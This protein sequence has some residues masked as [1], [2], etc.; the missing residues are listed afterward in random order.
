MKENE[1]QYE[2]FEQQPYKKI[3]QEVDINSES[4]YLMPYDY[5]IDI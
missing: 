5:H 3:K 4:S 1:S 2:F